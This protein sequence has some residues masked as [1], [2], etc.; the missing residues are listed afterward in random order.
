MVTLNEIRNALEALDAESGDKGL[1]YFDAAIA[2]LEA[3][4]TALNTVSVR[5]RNSVDA[6]LG[7]MIGIDM[8]IG[9]EG[10]NG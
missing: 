1:E 6:L 10:D 7:C 9:K 4:N 2:N 3:V 5:G 8:I